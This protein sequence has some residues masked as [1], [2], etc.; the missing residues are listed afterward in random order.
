MQI[1]VK[2]SKKNILMIL[3]LLVGMV[4]T[5]YGVKALYQYTHAYS[6]EN[7]TAGS[8]KEGIYVS[9]DVDHCLYKTIENGRMQNSWGGIIYH[10]L[11]DALNRR[12]EY[13]GY[14]IPLYDG[15]Y[16]EI[17]V[18]DEAVINKLDA[19]RDG[20]GEK[21]HL[22]GIIRY[23]PIAYRWYEGM[24]ALES[25]DLIVPHCLLKQTDMRARINCLYAGLLFLLIFFAQFRFEGGKNSFVEKSE[26]ER[27]QKKD[28]AARSYDRDWEI[29]M[30]KRHIEHLENSMCKLRERCIVRIPVLL[31]GLYF[32]FFT[33]LGVGQLIGFLLIV[34]ALKYMVRYI[35]NQERPFCINIAQMFNIKSIPNEIQECKKRIIKLQHSMKI[36]Y[37][38]DLD[39][40]LLN[41]ETKVSEQSLS[42]INGLTEK[43]VL[44]T[45]ATARSLSS[46]SIVT[47]GLKVKIP[48]ITYNGAFIVQPD[49]GQVVVQTGFT[50]AEVTRVKN[51]L[52]KNHIHPLV[53]A[54]VEDEERV[55]WVT[56]QE[57]EG[58]RH[59]L[60]KRQNDKRMRPLADADKLY[61]G[62]VFYFTCIGEKEELTAVYESFT[63]DERFRCI[64]QQELYREEYWCEIM[65]REASKA[66]A[67]RKLKGML[68]CDKVVCFGD[69]VNDIP[70]FQTANEGYAVANAVDELLK[71]ST[72]MIGGNDSDGV[73]LWL[74]EHANVE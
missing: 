72:A 35:G 51:I 19:Y 63:G 27:G 10:G 9:G 17:A 66:T 36:L 70:M 45:Y 8:C 13:T 3:C 46:A 7:L 59:Y 69:G 50:D 44:F 5:L 11:D 32:F 37:V 60:S 12:I 43:G 61:E 31:T 15:T 55:S 18:Y 20:S 16:L 54:Y 56:G 64:L 65:P 26:Y 23:S 58:V 71:L 14:T 53:Y 28:I 67:I 25:V 52:E 49:T 74:A 68:G 40:T 39:G 41:S 38:T 34:D 33:G 42:I 6:L 30:E 48:V 73:A 47:E 1:Q 57:N 2:V 24:E 4:C 22:E 21:V 29:A 62:S